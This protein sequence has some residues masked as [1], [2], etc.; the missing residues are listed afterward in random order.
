MTSKTRTRVVFLAAAI[1]GAGGL[2]ALKGCASPIPNRDPSGQRFPTVEGASLEKQATTLPDD[3]GAA[4]AILLIGYK[5]SAQ[6]DI[7][8]WLMGLLQAGADARIVEVPTI[9]GLVP[10][11]ASKWIDDGMRSGIPQE[12]WASVVT[13]YGDAA[14]PVAE[15]TG[16]ER[17]RLARVIVLDAAGRVAWFD[18]DGYSVRKAMEIAALVERMGAE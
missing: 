8:R 4:P 6:F 17:G 7:D 10:T 11:M 18:D 1:A 15:L 5:Q 12:D 3:L 2:L 16:T 9:P 14:R 13:L